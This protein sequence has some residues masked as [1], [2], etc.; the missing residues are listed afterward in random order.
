MI[1]KQELKD[2][3]DKM[4]YEKNLLEIKINQNI[5]TEQWYMYYGKITVYDFIIPKLEALL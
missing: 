3:L 1:D 2:I 4:K 5:Q